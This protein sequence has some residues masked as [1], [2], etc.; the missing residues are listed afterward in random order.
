MTLN[1]Q[2]RFPQLD[3]VLVLNKPKGPTSAGCLNTIKKHFGQ[4]RIGHAGTLDPMAQGVLVVLLGQA[5]KIAPHVVSG[6]KTYRGELRL[7]L[8]TDT[9]D[10]E[11]RITAEH[12]WEQVTDEQV[13]EE[14][15]GCT[16]LERQEVPPFA[17]A[18][19]KGTPLYALARAGKPTPTKT[20][21]VHIDRAEVLDMDLPLVRFRV[22]CSQGTYI[23]SLAHSLGKRLGCG[24][25]LTELVRES[26]RPF[27]IAQAHDLERLLAEPEAFPGRVLS[28]R[29][30]L[31]DWPQIRLDPELE[32]L[33]RNGVRLPL[34]RARP[35]TGRD[36]VHKA[37]LL[38]A[39]GSPLCLAELRDSPQGPVWA[40]V[41][42]LWQA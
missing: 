29:Q 32:G 41:R 35:G 31:A 37:L 3:G 22:V 16:G 24:A 38:G 28:L 4:R 11:G 26:S 2:Q 17:A 10:I 12:P 33:V 1:G 30:A 18:K 8:E 39:D 27:D 40:I 20:K 19:H 34:D 21:P 13:R 7:G 14:F 6:A 9:F 36:N 23:R 15:L 42:G 25:V 5:T